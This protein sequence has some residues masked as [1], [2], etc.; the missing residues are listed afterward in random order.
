MAPVLANVISPEP[1]HSPGVDDI[2]TLYW[3]AIVA[4]VLLVVAINGALIYAVARYRSERGAELTAVKS[5]VAQSAEIHSMSNAGGV[6]KMRKLD[7]LVLPAGERVE[8]KPDGNHIM[9]FDI[10]RQLRPGDT[11]PITLILRQGKKTI[12]IDVEAPVREAQ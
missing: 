7:K 11:V 1:S 5:P 4:I 3:I 12:P 8:L 2:T 10:K 9:L 6:M